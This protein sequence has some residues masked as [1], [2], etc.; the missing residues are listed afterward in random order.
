LR[1]L[2]V[3]LL[4]RRQNHVHDR[5]IA[6]TNLPTEE[7]RIREIRYILKEEL[8]PSVVVNIQYMVKFLAELTRKSKTNKMTPGNLGIVLGPTLMWRTGGGAACEQ[9][10]IERVIKA[11]AI[12][13]EHYNDIFPVDISWAQY[14]EGVIELVQAINE[15]PADAE[16]LEAMEAEFSPDHRRSVTPQAGEASNRYKRNTLRTKLFSKINSTFDNSETTG[17]S[18]ESSP[19]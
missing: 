17:A 10:N 4:G 14:D 19:Q 9:S 16:S 15:L 5:W 3:P 6:V 18:K 8:P 1:E 11:V 12:L 13:V 7:A 2:P